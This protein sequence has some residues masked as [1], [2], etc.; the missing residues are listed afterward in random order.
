MSSIQSF[1]N[2]FDGGLRPNRFLVNGEFPSGIGTDTDQF[3]FHVRAASIP[4]SDLSQ[5]GVPFRGREYKIPGN[6]SYATWQMTIIDDIQ[7]PLWTRFHQWAN[8]INSHT[9]N[10][11]ATT[12]TTS[13][14]QN[15]NFTNFMKNWS[16]EQ[17]DL[18]GNCV[19]KISLSNC[20]PSV[21]GEISFLMEENESFCTFTVD[22]EYQYYKIDKCDA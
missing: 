3:T 21:I 22:L 12:S 10:T 4:S 5:I 6:R 17:L 16:I 2:N 20:W 9:L 14:P 18:N 7:Y 15:Y 1:I 19:R 11:P 8:K 13:S